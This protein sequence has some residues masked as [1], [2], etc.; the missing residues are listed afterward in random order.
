MNE[1]KLNGSDWRALATATQFIVCMT[2]DSMT[3]ARVGKTTCHTFDCTGQSRAGLYC[4]I[5]Q[6]FAPDGGYLDKPAI[7]QLH[8]A[9]VE[10]FPV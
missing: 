6:T 4:I 7:P 8:A 1:F 5:E 10:R 9:F 2:P 3:R